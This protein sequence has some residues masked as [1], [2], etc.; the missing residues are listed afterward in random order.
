M[1][2]GIAQ[3]AQEALRGQVIVMI[4]VNLVDDENGMDID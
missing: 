1:S 4:K 2:Q 3:S